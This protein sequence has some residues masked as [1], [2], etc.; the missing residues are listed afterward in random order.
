LIVVRLGSFFNL[1]KIRTGSMITHPIHPTTT[2]TDPEVYEFKI[3]LSNV[4]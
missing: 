1:Q 4:H 2:G 3:L